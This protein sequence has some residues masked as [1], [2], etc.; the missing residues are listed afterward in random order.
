MVEDKSRMI[1][2]TLLTSVQ[3]VVPSS[4]SHMWQPCD[5][6]HHKPIK[7]PLYQ[8]R[9]LLCYRTPF[10]IALSL[11]GVSEFLFFMS[12]MSWCRLPLITVTFHMFQAN[13]VSSIHFQR[14]IFCQMLLLCPIIKQWVMF[15]FIISTC[16][17]ER[18]RPSY[19]RGHARAAEGGLLSDLKGLLCLQ[20]GA[21]SRP[22]RPLPDQWDS[23][24][25]R[26]FRRNSNEPSHHNHE[27]NPTLPTAALWEPQFRTTGTGPLFVIES[28]NFEVQLLLNCLVI[29][30]FFSS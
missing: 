9:V 6:P 16:S 3:T 17:R 21:G 18:L 7:R 15:F 2:V 8:D 29:D 13:L 11:R 5:S 26:G 27:T 28:K 1:F 24:G 20:K 25:R 10:N 12:R 30:L 19:K 22:W 23:W 14:P 4:C